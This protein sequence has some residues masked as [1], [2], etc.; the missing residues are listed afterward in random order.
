MHFYFCDIILLACVVDVV[1]FEN[2]RSSGS[3]VYLNVFNAKR[4][5]S[6]K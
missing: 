2:W 6:M 5:T 4:Y 1:I 3:E